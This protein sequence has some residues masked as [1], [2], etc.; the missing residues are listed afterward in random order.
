VTVVV[1]L[2]RYEGEFGVLSDA[3]RSQ[4]DIEIILVIDDSSS[5]SRLR[6]LCE[7]AGLRDVR[8]LETPG[9][10]GPAAA[11]NLGAA[12][13]TRPLLTFLDHDDWIPPG[14]LSALIESTSERVVAYDSSVIDSSGRVVCES[15][16]AAS[17]WRGAQLDASRAEALLHGF[18][19]IKLVVDADIFRQVGG[20]RPHIFAIEDFDLSWRLLAAGARIVFVDAS[21]GRYVIRSDSTTQRIAGREL[22][23]VIR[24]TAS[25]VEVWTDIANCSAFAS[26]VRRR[27]RRSARRAR[28]DLLKV[29]VRGAIAGDVSVVGR[30]LHSAAKSGRVDR[31]SLP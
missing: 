15:L 24:A 14:H 22:P 29:A 19:L 27:A 31:H 21:R 2:Y 17:T 4:G 10:V 18:P 13:A 9:Q 20:F 30:S 28:M 25:W 16:W 11:R 6:D 7:E 1:P 26:R 23:L 8:V 12:H 3:L 5:A